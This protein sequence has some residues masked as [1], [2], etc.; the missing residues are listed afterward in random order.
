MSAVS[1][2]IFD[3]GRWLEKVIDSCKTDEHTEGARKLLDLYRKRI[4]AMESP[5]LLE[6]LYFPL[7]DRICRKENA[8]L[9]AK[10]PF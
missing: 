5:G 2:N 7:S 1:S 6:A 4:V 10:F 3:I 9:D 8:I